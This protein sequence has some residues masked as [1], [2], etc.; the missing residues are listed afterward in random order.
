MTME[1]IE[2]HY[3]EN[4]LILMRT[5]Y[6]ISFSQNIVEYKEVHLL[7]IS[8]SLDNC[9]PRHSESGHRLS[10][11]SEL[12]PNKAIHVGEAWKIIYLVEPDS[13][14]G[15]T[16]QGMIH[17]AQQEDPSPSVQRSAAFHISPARPW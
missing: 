10:C 8:A 1:K 2:N 15:L 13:P 4:K 9:I 5:L 14:Q 12:R 11:R 3:F 6:C 7:K 16:D 17:P